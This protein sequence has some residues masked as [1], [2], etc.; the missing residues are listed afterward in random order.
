MDIAQTVPRAI[1]S[2][3]PLEDS[4]SEEG[5]GG[6]FSKLTTMRGLLWNERGRRQL[7]SLSL[8]AEVKGFLRGLE[9][10]VTY[11]VS[12]SPFWLL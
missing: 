8:S 12:V 4:I 7:F 1:V 6:N 2:Y 5:N 3:R 9:I 11:I 10:Y